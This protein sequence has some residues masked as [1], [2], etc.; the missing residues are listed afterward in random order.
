MSG[1]LLA[2]HRQVVLPIKLFGMHGHRKISQVW[3]F[4]DGKTIWTFSN[5]ESRIKAIVERKFPNSDHTECL[6]FH[7]SNLQKSS[8]F[9]VIIFVS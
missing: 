8:E 9:V 4:L 7:T 1:T 2:E 3:A 6:P 5:F